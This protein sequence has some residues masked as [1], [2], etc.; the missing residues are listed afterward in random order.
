MPLTNRNRH[1][2]D[3]LLYLSLISGIIPRTYA[4]IIYIKFALPTLPLLFF[5]R[6]HKT[7]LHLCPDQNEF[8]AFLD[9]Q[10]GEPH[11]IV[12]GVELA[13]DGWRKT[14]EFLRVGGYRREGSNLLAEIINPRGERRPFMSVLAKRKGLIENRKEEE[15]ETMQS[16]HIIPTD[17]NVVH[18]TAPL[19]FQ[20]PPL[21]IC[22]FGQRHGGDLW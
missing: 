2:F 16:L 6:V 22:L 4:F 15:K 1:F 9:P 14:D 3:N 11:G 13:L 20:V 5:Y 19:H 12:R 21:F 17:M 7:F 8:T 10:M 18:F